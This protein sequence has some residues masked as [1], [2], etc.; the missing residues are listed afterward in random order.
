MVCRMADNDNRSVLQVTADKDGKPS[1]QSLNE[2]LRQI[3]M[4]SHKVE[5]RLGEVTLRDD[6]RVMGK[7]SMEEQAAQLGESGT[8]VIYFDRE[9][10]VLKASEDGRAMVDLIAGDALLQRLTATTIGPALSID[11]YVGGV[12]DRNGAL[13]NVK[14][15]GAT[16]NGFT[17]DTAAVQAAIDAA[18][19]SPTTGGSAVY[20][21]SGLYILNSTLTVTDKPISFIGTGS[22]TSRLATTSAVA[23]LLSMSLNC[24]AASYPI[25]IQ[26]LEFTTTATPKTAGTFLKIAATNNFNSGLVISNC[27]FTAAWIALELENQGQAVVENC[28]IQALAGGIGVK[29]LNTG[30][31]SADG[32]DNAI[33]NCQINDGGS[34]ALA[35]IYTD[36]GQAGLRLTSNKI[37]GNFTSA[38]YCTNNNGDA[39]ADLK[40]LGNSIELYTANGI[41][42]NPSGTISHVLIQDNDLATLSGGAEIGINLNPTATGRVDTVLI[43]GN[44]VYSFPLGTT[45]GV[46]SSPPT[47]DGVVNMTIDNN[48]FQ[49]N[50]GVSIG[51]STGRGR[52][53]HNYFPGC[54][55]SITNNAT[56]LFAPHFITA[57]RNVVTSE[58]PGGNGIFEM[59]TEQ[60]DA[61]GNRLGLVNFCDRN[62]TG[63]TKLVSFI[64]GALEGATANNRGSRLEFTTKANNAAG[65]T[66][67]VRIDSNGSVVLAKAGALGTT[68]TDGFTY[69]PTCA[70]APTGVPTAYAGTVAMIYDT[71]NN[72]FYIYNG[73]WKKVLLA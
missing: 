61:D 31:L 21:P 34:G 51:A 36:R 24:A 62:A 20:F 39:G 60:A 7:V 4:N 35:G 69:I 16:G 15:Y 28:F 3:Q 11:R 42:L 50:T 18:G 2:V 33:I 41:H 73:A 46:S 54:T 56:G 44:R 12:W 8:G 9:E 30:G 67:R 17:D 57:T 45:I 38:V 40:I 59:S 14:A 25:H 47:A 32:G 26:D 6:T 55:T 66:E 71:T 64:G 65:S 29:L 48:L 27:K 53:S 10:G 58:G 72:N 52:A 22:G 13:F 1:L 37:L 68:A 23:N 43:Q 5:G 63:G 19:V 70:G 49:V